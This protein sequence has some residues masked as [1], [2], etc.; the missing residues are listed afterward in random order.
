MVKEH[1]KSRNV[2]GEWVQILDEADHFLLD[3]NEFDSKPACEIFGVTATPLKREV[4]IEQRLLKLLDFAVLD[5]CV[6]PFRDT[7]EALEVT[8]CAT[9]FDS[10]DTLPR[11]V[12][13]GEGTVT[14]RA[15]H[16]RAS[17]AGLTVKSSP[18]LASLYRNLEES[19]VYLL[20]PD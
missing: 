17:A 3:K 20:K 4:C 6:T 5:S 16:E 14:E 13:V 11:L 19:H 1:G 7:D 10:R 18:K 9:F 12:Y 2:I 8:S 15:V